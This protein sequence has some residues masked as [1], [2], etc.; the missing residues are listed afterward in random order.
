MEQLEKKL[1]VLLAN[2]AHIW[3]E[4]NWFIT[5]SLFLLVLILWRA[6]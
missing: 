3:R 5:L 6:W 2:Q 4:L 1:D